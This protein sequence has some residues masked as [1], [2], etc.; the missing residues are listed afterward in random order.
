MKRGAH[1]AVNEFR[2]RQTRFSVYD[3]HGV[4]PRAVRH[5][6]E[7]SH[8]SGD[9][10][11]VQHEN[12]GFIVKRKIGKPRFFHSADGED[13]VRFILFRDAA[14]HFFADGISALR[15][16]QEFF[17]EGYAFVRIHA[18]GRNDDALHE[19]TV[20]QSERGKPKAFRDE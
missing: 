17:R 20:F 4:S 7:R 15:D 10:D 2:M 11:P 13:P 14:K 9:L 1:R 19:K 18:F 12:D 6:N 5:A 8:I 16:F 3:K